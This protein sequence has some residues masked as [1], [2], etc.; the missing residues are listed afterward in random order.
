MTS[1]DIAGLTKAFNLTPLSGEIFRYLIEY[2]DSK[3]VQIRKSL[4]CE[5]TPFYRAIAA[6]E[7]S[8]FVSV[9]GARR[10]QSLVLND[11]N[12]IKSLLDAKKKSITDAESS[13]NQLTSSLKA[14]RD[15]RYYDKNVEIISG[16]DSYL[17]SMQA[18]ISGGGKVLRDITPDSE[19]LYSMAGSREKYE[20]IV[21]IIKSERLRRKIKIEILFDNQAK[22]IDSFSATSKLDLKESRVFDGN[23]KLDCYLNTCGN[24]TLFYTKDVKGS[25]GLIITDEFITKLLNSLFDVI[26]SQSRPL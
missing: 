10:S 13:L 6:L 5:R 23:L 17:R 1:N 26:W 7:S 2:G 4:K 11:L 18:L 25:W 16:Q 24:K 22:N 21:K 15:S 9:S 20:S 14:I 12:S 3:A 8:G 19:T